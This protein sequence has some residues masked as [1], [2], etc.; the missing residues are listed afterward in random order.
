MLFSLRKKSAQGGLAVERI[1]HG[2]DDDAARCGGAADDRAASGG[3]Q[4][5]RL[6]LRLFFV[7]LI[8]LH[9]FD[10]GGTKNEI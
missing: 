1:Y 2:A 8:F 9:N 6:A 10:G 3:L 4:G 7:L 5:V